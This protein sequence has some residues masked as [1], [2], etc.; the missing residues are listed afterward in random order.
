ML[1]VIKPGLF[2]TVQDLGRVGFRSQGVP[3]SGVF[4]RFSAMVAN[5]LVGNPTDAAVIE[6]TLVGGVFEAETQ[7]AIA[8]AGAPMRASI[9]SPKDSTRTLAI[10]QAATLRGGDRL[11]LGAAREGAR[12]YLAVRGGWL[13]PVVLGSRSAETALASGHLLP[14]LASQTPARRPIE[15]LFP[16]TSREA[17]RYLDGPDA[18]ILAGESLEHHDYVVSSKSN[19]MGLRLEGPPLAT[20]HD[21]CRLSSP[22]CPGAI[23]LPGGLPL[24]LGP[25][26]G[27]MGGYPHVGHVIAADLDRL[28]QLPPNSIMHFRRVG[29]AEAR[30]LDR[31]FWQQYSL[32]RLRLSSFQDW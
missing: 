26:C 30:G 23:Q 29:L 10:P 18:S 4:D 19:R 8:L 13:T 16:N 5:S 25:A 14:A 17:I 21:P 6:M 20:S 28:G 22:V 24:V 3:I 9:E 32:C 31:D 1:R 15:A 11:V 7:M 2:S 12:T 27:T